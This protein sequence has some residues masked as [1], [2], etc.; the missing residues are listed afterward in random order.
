MPFCGIS[1]FAIPAFLPVLGRIDQG[2]T[3]LSGRGSFA[4]IEQGNAE[5]RLGKCN[6]S[7]LFC[8]SEI[9]AR[10]YAERAGADDRLQSGEVLLHNAKYAMSNPT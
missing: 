1:R 9:N 6:D 4:F 5:P 7:R 10:I 8:F 2:A 3:A